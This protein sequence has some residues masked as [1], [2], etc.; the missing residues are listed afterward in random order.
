MCHCGPKGPP[1]PARVFVF[2]AAGDYNVQKGLAPQGAIAKGGGQV[3]ETV[4][5][6]VA[7][8]DALLR[9]QVRQAAEAE[10][11]ACDVAAD[12]IAALKAL[13]HG[14]YQLIVLD[15]ELPEVDGRVVCRHIRRSSRV[16]II[17]VGEGTGEAERLAGFSAGGNDYLLKPFYMRELMA[18]IRNLLDIFG[19]TG[20]AAALVN[21]GWLEVDP[22][23]RSAQAEGARLNLTPREYDLLLFFSRNPHQAFSRDALLDLVWGQDFEGGDRTVD[24]HVK[25]LRAKLGRRGGHIET[26]WGFGYRFEP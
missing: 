6:L 13:R 9:Q 4:L 11:W 22:A 21:H 25:S 24:T 12:G 8:A 5:L 3:P 10:G 16:P 17:F 23:Q 18:R 26:L 15:A 1:A 7:V 2:A 14:E 20:A 19:Y